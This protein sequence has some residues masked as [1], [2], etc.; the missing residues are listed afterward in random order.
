ME[1]VKYLKKMN[2]IAFA[3]PGQG[4]HEVGRGKDLIEDYKIAEELLNAANIAL[5]NE[6]IDL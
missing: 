2:K 4:S 3:F 5:K 6:G 1:S